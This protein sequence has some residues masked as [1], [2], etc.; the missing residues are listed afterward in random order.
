MPNKNLYE[1]PVMQ[2]ILGNTLRPGGTDITKRAVEFCKFKED[3]IILDLGCGKG[4]TIKYLSDNYNIKAKGLDISESL[5]KEAKTINKNNEIVVSSGENIPFYKDFF[6]GVFA[7]CTLSLMS[8]LEKTIDEVYRVIKPGG[9][10]IISDIYSGK[11]EFL[12]ELQG[13]SIN[14]CLRNP[15][16]LLKLKNLLTEKGFNILLEEKYDK[17]MKQLIVKIIFQYGS[18][19][20]FWNTSG[21]TCGCLEGQGFQ[22]AL[23]KSK[24]GYFLIIAHKE[25]LGY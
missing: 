24:L 18:M 2:D 12:E 4:A 16:N 19:E 11:T 13:Y 23:K 5:V 7:E 17:Y 15:H 6:D 21:V 1:E 9:Y 22:N 10:F 14:T 20:E 8:N 25:A 3:D